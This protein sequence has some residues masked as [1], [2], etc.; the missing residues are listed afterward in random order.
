MIAAG[1]STW[2]FVPETPRE[3]LDVSDSRKGRPHAP[4]QGAVASVNGGQRSAPAGRHG[5]AKAGIMRG[6]EARRRRPTF[7]TYKRVRDA[8]AFARKLGVG[9]VDYGNRLDIANAFNDGLF[10]VYRRGVPMPSRI[11][12]QEYFRRDA[13]EDPAEMAYYLAGFGDGPGEVH[14]NGDHPAW[15][16]LATAMTR[17]RENHDLST[18]DPR[19]PVVHEMGELAMHL[20]VG[21]ARFDPLHESYL[22]DEG[23]FQRL[24][25]SGVLDDI[26]DAV[27][28]RA[29]LNHAEFVAEVFA[30]LMLGRTELLGKAAVMDAYTRFGGEAIRRYDPNS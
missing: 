3:L 26:M 24:G 2:I 28:D 11:V 18:A 25:E 21:G 10:V 6:A 22:A 9:T 20:A 13:M 30:A 1:R 14:V 12:V 23:A 4:P 29:G 17:A 27:S 7:K 8:E 5:A 15:R 19:H 16:D